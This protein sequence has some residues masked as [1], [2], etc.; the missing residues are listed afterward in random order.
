LLRY[1]EPLRVFP[2]LALCAQLREAV[3]GNW[4]NEA[5]STFSLLAKS[6]HDIDL[7]MYWMGDMKCTKIQ[8]FGGLYHF[9]PE[10]KPKGASDRCCGC[11]AKRLS[12][13]CAKYLPGAEPRAPALADER[14]LRH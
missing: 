7:V 14:S 6:S 10:Q 2:V 3:R 5:E 1:C 12:L 9:R 8:S 4:R 11:A 13:L